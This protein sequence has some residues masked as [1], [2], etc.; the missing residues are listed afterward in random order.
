ME[1]PEVDHLKIYWHHIKD[2]FN[3]VKSKTDGSDDSDPQ[4]FSENYFSNIR[5][6]IHRLNLN[7]KRCDTE[8]TALIE[9]GTSGKDSGSK[10]EAERNQIQAET[11]KIKDYLKLSSPEKLIH[12]IKEGLFCCYHSIALRELH[13]NA[14]WWLHLGRA[15][16]HFFL[17]K[18]IRRYEIVLKDLKSPEKERFKAEVNQYIGIKNMKYLDRTYQLQQA[19]ENF[20]QVK[21]THTSG[22]AYKTL[23]Q[24]MY[25]LNDDFS[26]RT[27]HF[28]L[29]RERAELR[30][31]KVRKKI[32]EVLALTQKR[33]EKVGLLRKAQAKVDFS[34]FQKKKQD[35]A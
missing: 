35:R 23:I 7:E 28:L 9:S 8:F 11:Q 4:D 22:K 16:M 29:A 3:K 18:W 34:D 1:P 33:P 31:G 14:F 27:Y 25:Y 20:Q 32:D 12:E 17:A 10:T 15:Y 30:Q 24:R 13:R 21:E 6:R 5:E 19:L 26:D 2:K